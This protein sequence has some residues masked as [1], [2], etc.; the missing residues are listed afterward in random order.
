M[1]STRVRVRV[2]LCGSTISQM[3]TIDGQRRPDQPH[4]QRADRVGREGGGDQEGAGDD[5]DPADEDRGPDGG[6]GGHEDRDAADH[7]RED[8]DG[9]QRLPAAGQAVA[10]LRIHRCSSDLHGRNPK[11]P[12]GRAR[13]PARRS[14]THLRTALSETP[15]LATDGAGSSSPRSPPG[16]AHA[17]VDPLFAPGRPRP[18]RAA[19][20]V[21]AS[22]ASP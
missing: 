18:A 11:R 19:T 20:A 3:P 13:A 15:V 17:A 2:P 14:R 10:H 5:E 6:D 7:D 4:D 12:R 16:A 9:H 22:P 8:A 21:P 1:P